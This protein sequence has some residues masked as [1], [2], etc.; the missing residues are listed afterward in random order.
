MSDMGICGSVSRSHTCEV[1]GT[2]TSFTGD[3]TLCSNCHKLFLTYYFEHCDIKKLIGPDEC[4]KYVNLD[5]CTCDMQ[6]CAIDHLDEFSKV[7]KL[8]KID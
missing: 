2:F 6:S 4:K 7:G 3:A 1:C 8:A 5:G